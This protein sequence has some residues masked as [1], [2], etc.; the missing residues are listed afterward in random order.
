MTRRTPGATVPILIQTR[1]QVEDFHHLA[2]RHTETC[3][4]TIPRD[5]PNI[6]QWP[7]QTALLGIEHTPPC[8]HAGT[9]DI[10]GGLIIIPGELAS[11]TDSGHWP[12]QPPR[13]PS[14][15]W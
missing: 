5:L 15:A 6:A 11:P 3:G 7:E 8:T 4:C 1:H 13:G 2:T 14:R 9:F 12:D 10:I